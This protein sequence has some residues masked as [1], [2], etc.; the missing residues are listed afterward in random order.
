MLVLLFGS[1]TWNLTEPVLESL[2]GFHLWA[3]YRVAGMMPQMDADGTWTYPESDKVLEAVGLHK[4]SH[5]MEVRRQTIANFIVN[6]SIF[7]LCWQGER[8]RGSPRR[9]FWWEQPMDLAA[10]AAEIAEADAEEAEGG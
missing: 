3:A 7:E 4:I 9:Q 8:K 5:Y 6:Q 2:E 1:E 10:A